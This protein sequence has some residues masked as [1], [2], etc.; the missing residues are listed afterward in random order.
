MIHG[1]G[2]RPRAWLRSGLGCKLLPIAVSRSARS[3][4]CRKARLPT[5][6]I[7]V[8]VGF[9][10]GGSATSRRE[11]G[12]ERF[13]SCSDS[14]SGGH[15]SGASGSSAPKSRRGRHTNGYTLL[16]D[17]DDDPWHWATLYQ[18]LPYNPIRALS[19]LC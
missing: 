16:E 5:K 10:P 14:R 17:H 13:P 4:G 6:P 18:K 1:T 9:A 2:V 15:R 3:A 12:A 8:I 7:S 19:P 11:R